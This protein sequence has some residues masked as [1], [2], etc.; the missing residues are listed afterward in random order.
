[1]TRY[2][3]AHRDTFGVEPI[4]QTLEVAPSTYYAARSRPPSRR[5][6]D[7][8]QL[9]PKIRRVHKGNFAVYGA[10]K[11]WRQLRREDVDV[12]RDRVA[13]LTAELGLC[14]ATR[15]KKVRTTTEEALRIAE[16]ERE[17][18]ELR[19]ANEILKSASAFFA[20][21]LDRPSKR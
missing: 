17:N 21:E 1:M 14:G 11:V 5:A 2:I 9:K 13:R 8:A 16:L 20:A 3:D 15:T 18:R 19:R 10:R 7:D 6:Q 12:G 4:C